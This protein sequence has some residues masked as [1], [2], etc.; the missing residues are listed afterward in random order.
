MA[1]SARGTLCLGTSSPCRLRGSGSNMVYNH[2]HYLCFRRQ[3][4]LQDRCREGARGCCSHRPIRI[5]ASG[6]LVEDAGPAR[7]SLPRLREFREPRPR[8]PCKSMRCGGQ[9]GII[10]NTSP[11]FVSRRPCCG[12]S[13]LGS[14]PPP[15]CKKMPFPRSTRHPWSQ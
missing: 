9:L 5:A 6:G 15:H 2:P 1:R 3:R 8:A 12:R 13:R 7:T 14:F 4:A 11:G 10:D